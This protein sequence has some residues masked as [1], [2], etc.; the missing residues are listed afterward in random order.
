MPK[1]NFN[2]NEKICQVTCIK[3][4]I[5]KVTVQFLGLSH[6]TIAGSDGTWSVVLEKQSA[7]GPYEMEIESGKRI[8]LHGVYFGDVRILS[9]QSNMQLPMERVKD[10]I[11]GRGGFIKGKPYRLLSVLRQETF[12]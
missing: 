7:G 12:W 8:I 1:T 10:K 4:Y 9:G 2:Q 6:V 5:A 11:S 3:T